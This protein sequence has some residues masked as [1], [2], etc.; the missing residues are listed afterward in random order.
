[1]ASDTTLTVHPLFI[2]EPVDAGPADVV[3]LT[4]LDPINHQRAVLM[5]T[6]PRAE[7]EPILTY[8]VSAQN[9][10]WEAA[11]L[12]TLRTLCCAPDMCPICTDE[13][14]HLACPWT[15][16]AE[17]S[18]ASER[19]GGDTYG[20]CIAHQLEASI[21]RPVTVTA[22]IIYGA[23][24]TLILHAVTDGVAVLARKGCPVERIPVSRITA[25][26]VHPA[27]LAGIQGS[28]R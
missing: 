20:P 12:P 19:E 11:N 25:V 17:C 22:G 4:A 16:A 1:M 28:I 3:T 14:G 6:G 23:A 2:L 26:A 15:D 27:V 13:G 10:A 21:G 24:G 18:L 8:L 7:V 5:A 9:R